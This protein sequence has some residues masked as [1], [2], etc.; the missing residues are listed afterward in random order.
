VHFYLKTYFTPKN[1]IRQ[2]LSEK[3]FNHRDLTDPTDGVDVSSLGFSS[4][5]V[6]GVL[7][8]GVLPMASGAL[9][10][11]T[12]GA[13]SMMEINSAAPSSSTWK[14]NNPRVMSKP[15]V[16]AKVDPIKHE[17]GSTTVVTR[18]SAAN[19]VA[20]SMMVG[21]AVSTLV[22]AVMPMM[23]GDAVS[24]LMADDVALMSMSIVVGEGA[25]ESIDLDPVVPTVGAN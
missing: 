25:G 14:L 17:I 18:G 22:G 11:V 21:E 13:N 8:E 15:P 20:D 2:D 4:D 16:L 1:K 19:T 5:G 3:A 12:N 24:M 7:V 23:V 10:S 9:E 6:G